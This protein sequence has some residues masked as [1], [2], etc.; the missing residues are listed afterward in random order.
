NNTDYLIADLANTITA[1]ARTESEKVYAIYRWITANIKYDNR[2]RFSEKL[3][4][5][6]YVSEENVVAHVLERK[7][8]LCGGFAFLFRDLCE[9]VDIP[10]EAIHGYSKIN[11]S[12]VRNYEKPNHTWNAVKLNGKWHLLDI[13]WAV[14][15]GN[16]KNPDDFWYLTSP[17]DF[18]YSHY[19]KNPEWTL[20]DNS[21]SFQKFKSR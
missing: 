8:A 5:E 7:M 19:P 2:L 14:G 9:E 6:I 12:T 3:Q 17:E 16:A 18:I 1:N 20:L 10:V 4:K 15:F 13:T 11:G 21:I